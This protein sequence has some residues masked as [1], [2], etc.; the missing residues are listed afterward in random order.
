ML[1]FSS[2][3]FC[4]KISRLYDIKPYPNSEFRIKDLSLF[5]ESLLITGRWPM[6][7]KIT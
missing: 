5:F 2:R 3:D 7:L 1:I 4:M 6:E